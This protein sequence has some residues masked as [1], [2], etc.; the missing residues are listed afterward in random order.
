MGGLGQ[1]G[2]AT[3]V[4]SVAVSQSGLPGSLSNS[5]P[6]APGSPAKTFPGLGNP[7]GPMGQQQYNPVQ[8]I[9]SHLQSKSKINLT[10]LFLYKLA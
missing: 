8:N 9:T 7:V 6:G 2:G 5:L 10:N 1:V 4:P 3:S